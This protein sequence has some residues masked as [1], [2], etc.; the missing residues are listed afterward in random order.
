MYL[1]NRVKTCRTN[2]IVRTVKYL[3]VFKYLPLFQQRS[4]L[5][6]APKNVYI[7]KKAKAVPS[8]AWTDPEVSRSLRLPDFK[9]IGTWRW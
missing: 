6:S 9:T 1:L 3:T 8:Q 7:L 4:F 2:H 5:C